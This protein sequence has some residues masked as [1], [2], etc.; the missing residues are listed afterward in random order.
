MTNSEKK[1]FRLIQNDDLEKF[2]ESFLN[3]SYINKDV[4]NSEG[5]SLIGESV[6]RGSIKIAGFIISEEEGLI[7]SI[8]SKGNKPLA[9]AGIIEPNEEMINLFKKHNFN[10][11]SELGPKGNILHIISPRGNRNLARKVISFTH[12]NLMKKNNYGEMPKDI[13]RRWGNIDLEDFMIK[14]EK[15][16]SEKNNIEPSF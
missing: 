11:S 4:L 3:N 16:N 12:D 7:D 10:F 6:K 1:L 2:K 8:D 15:I 5:I 13:A 14:K 9:Y